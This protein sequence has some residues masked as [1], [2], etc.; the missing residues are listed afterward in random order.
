MVINCETVLHF[1]VIKIHN[2]LSSQM[3]QPTLHCTPTQPSQCWQQYSDRTSY[4]Q[5]TVPSIS[6]IS[7]NYFAANFLLPNTAMKH[8]QI[9]RNHAPNYLA[10][11]P[12]YTGLTPYIF[13]ITDCHASRFSSAR[14]QRNVSSTFKNTSTP[15][16]ESFRQHGRHHQ[17]RQKISTAQCGA[18][19]LSSIGVHSNDFTAI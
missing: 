9:I 8:D 11:S 16:A 5:I 7:S 15:A 12:Y 18:S 3:K 14:F 17:G 4:V 13:V 2:L 1:A 19:L 10:D 6:L